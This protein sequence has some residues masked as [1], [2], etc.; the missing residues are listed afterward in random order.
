[1]SAKRAGEHALH[2]GALVDSDIAWSPD[3]VKHRSRGDP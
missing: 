2:V 1:M 3:T